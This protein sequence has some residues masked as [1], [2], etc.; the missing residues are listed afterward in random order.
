MVRQGILIVLSGPSGTGKGTICQRIAAKVS[1]TCTI[2]YRPLPVCL[3]LVKYNGVNYWFTS[4]K[5]FQ[6]MIEQWRTA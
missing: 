5:D 4:H 3:D 1:R 2:P 6:N